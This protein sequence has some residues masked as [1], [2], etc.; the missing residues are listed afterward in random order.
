MI[1]HVKFLKTEDDSN[2][3]F[4][5]YVKDGYIISRYNIEEQKSQLVG[6]TDEAILALFVTPNRLRDKDTVYAEAHG[7]DIA[8]IEAASN[9]NRS[10]AFFVVCLDESQKI[11]VFSNVASKDDK[12]FSKKEYNL[13]NAQDIGP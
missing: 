1:S 7:K 8:D 11:Y 13:L 4:I 10:D 6:R 5:F 12:T 9:G 3:K 2:D